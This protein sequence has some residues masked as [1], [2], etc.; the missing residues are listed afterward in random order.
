MNTHKV[1]EVGIRRWA[2][3]SVHHGSHGLY[4]ISSGESH[5]NG[6]DRLPVDPITTHHHFDEFDGFDGFDVVGVPFE[7][8]SEIHGY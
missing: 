4:E 2:E 8:K 3:G 5:G 6:M 1:I 7:A